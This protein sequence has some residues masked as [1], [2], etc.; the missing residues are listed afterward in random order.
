MDL[1]LCTG[2]QSC[3]KIKKGLSPNSSEN[4]GNLALFK[5]SGYAKVEDFPSLKRKHLKSS[6]IPLSLLHKT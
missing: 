4:F 5:M 1:A 2:A 3:W 6:P